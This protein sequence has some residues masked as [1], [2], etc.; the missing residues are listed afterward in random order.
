MPSQFSWHPAQILDIEVKIHPTGFDRKT[1]CLL[2]AAQ[3]I[4]LKL[5]R[6]AECIHHKEIIL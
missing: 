2:A 1:R 3:D 5:L 4:T 6:Q